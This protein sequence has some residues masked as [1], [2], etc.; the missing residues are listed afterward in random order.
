MAD[1]QASMQKLV[2]KMSNGRPDQLAEVQA[3]Q[4]SLKTAMLKKNFKEHPAMSL[5]IATLRKREQAYCLILQNKRDLTEVQRQAFFEK[6]DE[7]RLILSFFKVESVIDTIEKELDY[8]LSD[9]V[10]PL[11]TPAE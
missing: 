8:Q 9:D 7:L 1:P 4:R 6:R 2:E 10:T 5:F 3:M 11:S